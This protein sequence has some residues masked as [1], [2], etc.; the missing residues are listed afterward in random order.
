MILSVKNYYFFFV[1]HRL[2]LCCVVY[3]NLCS[4]F[5]YIYIYLHSKLYS[6]TTFLSITIN[7]NKILIFNQRQTFTTN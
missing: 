3:L 6:S 1:H 4:G 7:C 5:L 2:F